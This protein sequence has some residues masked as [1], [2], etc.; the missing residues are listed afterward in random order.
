M[1][2]FQHILFCLHDLFKVTFE[3]MENRIAYN[4][5]PLIHRI[6]Y[7]GSFIFLMDK[8]AHWLFSG[9]YFADLLIYIIS[10]R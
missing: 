4:C 10:N 5:L 8:A 7:S 6:I 1:I 3:D 2:Y 9:Y